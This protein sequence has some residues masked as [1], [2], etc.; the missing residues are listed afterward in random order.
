MCGLDRG[1]LGGAE[2]RALALDDE[3]M[4]LA[5][6]EVVGLDLQQ[7]VGDHLPGDLG[8]LLRALANLRRSATNGPVFDQRVA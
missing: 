8:H 1:D 3:L 5:A 7:A 2:P 4:P 6:G